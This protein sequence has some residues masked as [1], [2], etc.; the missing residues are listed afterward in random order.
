MYLVNHT[1]THTLLHALVND[2]MSGYNYAML[3]YIS[4]IRWT[5]TGAKGSL[6]ASMVGASRSDMFT[7][8]LVLIVICVL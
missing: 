7:C 5:G 4:Y 6:I 1:H 3:C 2:R 8:K